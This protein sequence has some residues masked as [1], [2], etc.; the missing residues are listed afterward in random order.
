MEYI[1]KKNKTEMSH[2]KKEGLLKLSE[3]IQW[4]R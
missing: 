4:G 3:I 2:K 1:I